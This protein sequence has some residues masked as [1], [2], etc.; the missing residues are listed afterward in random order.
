MKME[1]ACGAKIMFLMLKREIDI[2]NDKTEEK[3]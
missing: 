1:Q 2:K 3:F